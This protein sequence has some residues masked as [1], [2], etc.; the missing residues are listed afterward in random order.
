M[1]LYFPRALEITG[2]EDDFLNVNKLLH[3][4]RKWPI[5]MALSEKMLTLQT[6][7]VNPTDQTPGALGV[8][9]E[10]HSSQVGLFL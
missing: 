2:E 10:A 5:E 7:D 9:G 8:T 4:M 3:L 6:E 1:Q